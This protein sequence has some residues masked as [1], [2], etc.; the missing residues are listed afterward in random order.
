MILFPFN[1]DEAS[2]P[3]LISHPLITF[4]KDIEKLSPK[5]VGA[6]VGN[7]EAL[8]EKPCNGEISDWMLG[9]N[10]IVAVTVELGN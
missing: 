10:N 8:K 7:C 3:N 4:Y 5:P 9:E 1:A 6:R 2:N